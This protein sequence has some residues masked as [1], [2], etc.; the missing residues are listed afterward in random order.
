MSEKVII[1]YKDLGATPLECLNELKKSRPELANTPLTYAGRL[2]PM[3]EGLMIVLVGEEC[4]NK[5][6][7]L[8]L[9]KTYEFE[10]LV[11]FETDTYD[12]LG[13]VVSSERMQFSNEGLRMVW[14]SFQE[15]LARRSED[16]SN[17]LFENGKMDLFLKSFVGTFIQKYPSFSSKTVG[18]KQL[19]QLYKDDELPQ[20]MPEHEVTVHDLKQMGIRSIVK[21]DLQTEILRRINLVHGDFR[22]DDI[23]QRWQEVLA[24]SKHDEF[25]IISCIMKCSSG[26]YVRQLVNDIGEKLRAPMVTYSI[27]RTQVGDFTLNDNIN[28]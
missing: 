15:N 5:G 24:E 13:L 17:S 8:G 26:T 10:I 9:D 25:Q 3:A 12:L 22:Q 27:K 2:D 7:Y 1:V 4:K 23:Q 20:E 14:P 16:L 19:F 28:T 21:E 18:G 11:G 6:A